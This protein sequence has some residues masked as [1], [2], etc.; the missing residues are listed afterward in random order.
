MVFTPKKYKR[1]QW[2]TGQKRSRLCFCLLLFY[3]DTQ[4]SNK[5][6]RTSMIIKLPLN[7]LTCSGTAI[8]WLFASFGLATQATQSSRLRSAYCY[9]STVC[10][11]ALLALCSEAERSKQ[12]PNGRPWSIHFAFWGNCVSLAA[13]VAGGRTA[14]RPLSR[15]RPTDRRC[16][17]RTS[18]WR[19]EQLSNLIFAPLDI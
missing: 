8:W 14:A 11:A 4:T 9:C 15:R 19:H 18:W 16:W 2:Q 1:F 6:V 7:V 3:N 13:G 17:N 5:Y 10:P 12:S